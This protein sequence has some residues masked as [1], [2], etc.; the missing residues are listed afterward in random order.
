MS[1]P[2]Q[3]YFQLLAIAEALRIS[4]EDIH[5]TSVLYKNGSCYTVV[6]YWRGESL[7]RRMIARDMLRVEK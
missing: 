5:C 3:R 2:Q 7:A 1:L 4:V 6:W